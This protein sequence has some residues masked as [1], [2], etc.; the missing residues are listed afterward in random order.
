MELKP[1]YAIEPGTGGIWKVARMPVGGVDAGGGG[2][3][4]VESLGLLVL[5]GMAL[6][7]A[8]AGTVL[9]LRRRAQEA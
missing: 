3:A 8:A 1:P 2:T 7:G 5:G 6:A 9:I 4:G